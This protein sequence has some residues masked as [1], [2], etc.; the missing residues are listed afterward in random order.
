MGRL[1]NQDFSNNFQNDQMIIPTIIDNDPYLQLVPSE[2][3][4]LNSQIFGMNS[5][6]QEIFYSARESLQQNKQIS[7]KYSLPLN[8]SKVSMGQ[9]PLV[10]S[11]REERIVNQKNQMNTKNLLQQASPQTQV[12]N[13]NLDMKSQKARKQYSGSS[14]QRNNFNGQKLLSNNNQRSQ[15]VNKSLKSPKSP[16]VKNIFQRNHSKKIVEEIKQQ[17]IEEEEK[18][19]NEYPPKR[20]S[21]GLG[22]YQTN[23][24]SQIIGDQMK[25]ETDVLPNLTFD[26]QNIISSDS[27]IMQ[28]KRKPTLMPFNLPGDDLDNSNRLQKFEELK[29]DIKI[30]IDQIQPGNNKKDK[31]KQ[32]VKHQQSQLRQNIQSTPYIDYSLMNQQELIKEIENLQK[33]M[34]IKDKKLTRAGQECQK[35]RKENQS[36]QIKYQFEHKNNQILLKN[37]NRIRQ[38]YFQN[39]IQNQAFNERIVSVPNEITPVQSF[40]LSQSNLT[41]TQE[42][43]GIIGNRTVTNINRVGQ[44]SHQRVIQ[45]RVQNVMNQPDIAGNISVASELNQSGSGQLDNIQNLNIMQPITR[46]TNGVRR[47]LIMNSNNQGIIG[48]NIGSSNQHHAHRGGNQRRYQNQNQ[49]RFGPNNRTG[50]MRMRHNGNEEEASLYETQYNEESVFINKVN[51]MNIK[52]SRFDQPQLMMRNNSA[53]NVRMEDFIPNE[54]PLINVR[55]FWAGN[56]SHSYRMRIPQNQYQMN[57]PQIRVNRPNGRLNINPN[58][59]HGMYRRTNQNLHQQML[60]IRGQGSMHNIF[61]N[62]RRLGQN[63]EQGIGHHRNRGFSHGPPLRDINGDSQSLIEEEGYENNNN[64]ILFASGNGNHR[65]IQHPQPQYHSDDSQLDFEEEEKHHALPRN[66]QMFLQNYSFNNIN[67]NNMGPMIPGLGIHAQFSVDDGGMDEYDVAD[68]RAHLFEYINP[69]NMTYEELLALQER[70]GYVSKGLSREQINKFPRLRKKD[71]MQLIEARQRQGSRNFDFINQSEELMKLILKNP[72]EESKKTTK[73]RTTNMLQSRRSGNIMNHHLLVGDEDLDEVVD[74]DEGVINRRLPL[75]SYNHQT[76]VAQNIQRLNRGNARLR[77][78][79]DEE[80]G[81]ENCNE[82]DEERKDADLIGS[83]LKR[84]VIKER[85]LLLDQINQSQADDSQ[86]NNLEDQLHQ[87]Q[88]IS[89]S[90]SNQERCAICFDGM[91]NNDIVKLLTCLHYYHNDCIDQWLL[92]EKKCPMCMMYLD[93]NNQDR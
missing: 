61:N 58:V 68:E 19:P 1:L 2:S 30:G 87:S 31:N 20:A 5:Q 11:G 78:I 7:P 90:S 55:E 42:L 50:N 52:T 74:G 71:V 51:E 45:N 65:Q 89:Q 44:V 92:V 48:R 39:G 15:G 60:N 69:D 16:G 47:H 33:L 72:L 40:Q 75:N 25:N 12:Q 4:P 93:N 70:I 27:I 88:V 38:N 67:Q 8:L 28:Q 23:Y 86:G 56:Y 43:Q 62:Q 29:Q 76:Q 63:Q 77:V 73:K 13:K 6:K 80:E 37:L 36:L 79:N 41:F 22:Y 64:I 32:K 82:E 49:S 26:E 66:H 85:E 83:S 57:G 81:C 10:S 18:V 46:V 9:S 17:K 24:F 35:L 3:Q 21:V 84:Q 34:G 14:N 59:Q 91:K 54:E 53:M